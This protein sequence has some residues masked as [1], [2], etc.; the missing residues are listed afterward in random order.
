M[1]GWPHVRLDSVAR[2]VRGVTY[3]KGN[4]VQSPDADDVPILRA[5]NI[6]GRLVIERDLVWLPRSAVNDDQLLKLDDIVMCMSSGSAS[7]VGKSAQ[8]K[9]QWVG[10]FG[11]FCAAIRTD[12]SRADSSFIGHV[13][14]TPAFRSF[15]GAALG[16]NI[17]NLNKS[18]LE[19]Y[20]IPLP[21]LDE[22]RRIVGLL[23]RAA[24]IR[25]RTDAARSRARAIIP[26]LFLDTFGDPVTNPKG[27]PVAKLGNLL[28]RIDG[29]WSPVCGD[30][31]PAPDQWGVLKLSAVKSSGFVGAEAKRLPENVA[32]R[33]DLEVREGD[34]LFTRKNTIDLVGTATVA[35][36]SG[37]K[38][39]LPD[40]IFR[41]VS[42]NPARFVRQYVS[43]LINLPSFR[44]AIRQLAS[45]SA[46]SMPGI[47]KGR[48]SALEI[49]V[50]DFPLQTTFAEQARRIESLARALD[51][52]CA[53]AEAMA[54]ALSAEMFGQG[55]AYRRHQPRLRGASGGASATMVG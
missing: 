51:T 19:G 32:P 5:G 49:P 30:G 25:R 3:A 14:A 45:G 18:A 52:A 21:P 11:A 38:R 9:T 48:L 2:V 17:K 33:T 40:T 15:A 53:K 10:S 46:S 42:S 8:L 23:D 39:M 36:D 55:Q 24:E 37:R 44:P 41:L 31:V 1:S 26:A 29:G 16:N 28:D 43:A 35:D 27:W 7:V 20:Q 50:P 54:A 12:H 4:V 13:L 34:L 22:Q 47:S 6:N